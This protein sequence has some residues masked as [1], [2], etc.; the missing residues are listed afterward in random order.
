MRALFALPLLAVAACAPSAPRTAEA[1][2]RPELHAA[3]VAAPTP[4]A[5]AYVV[6]A[7]EPGASYRPVETVLADASAF[8]GEVV[9]VAGTI[10]QVC[11]TRGCWLTMADAQG[12]MLRVITHEEGAEEDEMLVFPMDA[13]GARAEVVGT[14]SV[15]EESVERRRHLAEDAGASAEEIA[16]ITEPSRSVSLLA[17]GARIVR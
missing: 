13:S 11:Q 16:A 4:A 15:I 9:H 14:L 2:S 10:R 1:P 17:V 3:P 6:G 8:D 12:R 5:D 7:F